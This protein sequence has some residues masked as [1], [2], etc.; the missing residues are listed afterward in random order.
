MKNNKILWTICC[1]LTLAS[2]SKKA[3]PIINPLDYVNPF[4][5]TGGHGHT[6]PGATVPFGMVQLSPDT[7]LEG[8][9]GCSGY[10]YS[11]S[12]IYGF[13]HTHLSGTG[14]SDYG[15]ILVMPFNSEEK[16]SLQ[17]AFNHQL[18][19]SLFDKKSEKASPGSYKV[20]IDAGKV[21]LTATKRVGIHEYKFNQR[22]NNKVFIDLNHRDKVLDCA[23]QLK[24][25][26]ITGKRISHAWAEEQHVYFAMEFS[27]PFEFEQIKNEQDTFPLFTVLNF[28][29]CEKLMVKVGISASSVE[30]AI[31]NL[32]TEAGHWDFEKYLK[33]AEETWKK[34]LSKI[35]VSGTNED[36][37]SIFYTALYHSMI[38]PNTISDVNGDYRGMD[39]K[40]YKERH[41]TQYTIFSLWDTFRGAHPLYTIIERKRTLAFIESMLNHYKQGGRLPV[42]E[43]SANETDCMIGYHSVSVIVDAYN[44]GI[45]GFDTALALEAMTHSANLDHLG[46]KAYKEKGFIAAGDEAESVSKTLEYAYD[47]WCIALFAKSMGK[48]SLFNEFIKRAQYYKNLYN[49]NNGF[50]QARMNGGWTQNFQPSEVNFNYTEANSWQ[51]SL[52]VPQDI[53][54]LIQLHGGHES[55]E[56]KLDELF[57]T[58]MELSGRHQVDITGLIGQYAHGNEPSHHMAY[59]Y[60]YI[61]KAYKTQEK[62]H[63]ILKEQYHNAPDGL[64]GNEDCGQMSAWYVLSSM[65]FYSVTPGLPYY[66]IGTPNFTKA[67]I[68]LE[69][70]KN[71]VIQANNLSAD[72]FYIQSA[73]LNGKPYT[74]SFIS[75]ENIMKGGTLAF[76]MGNKPN[77][78]WGKEKENQPIATIQKQ[79][80]TTA[81]P[82]IAARSQTFIDSLKI[83]IQSIDK[84]SAV[85]YQ[86]NEGAFKKYMGPFYIKKMCNIKAFSV[87]KNIQSQL[88]EADFYKIKGGRSIRILTPYSN[89]YAAAGDQTL[90]DYLRGSENYRT[91]YWQG[92]QGTNVEVIIDLGIPTTINKI[93][94]GTLQDIKSWIW[95]PKSVDLYTSVK[96]NKFD[97]LAHLNNEHS[98][99]QYGA[100]LQDFEATNKSKAKVKFVKVILNYPG[101]CPQ[102]HLGAGGKAWI[103]VDEV[104]IE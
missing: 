9:D 48:D 50:M 65:G 3:A 7:R 43:L 95:F 54:G 82:V 15:D 24:D 17:Q 39:Q 45:R 90:I 13:S 53:E 61:G 27:Q 47:D 21:R 96:G 62:V 34:A 78:N 58:Q 52:F 72:N 97:K 87:E 6:Y 63:Q 66:T 99:A 73:T 32:K 26:M 41:H 93:K 35:E 103:F 77:K 59:L 36:E 49:P 8:W 89:Q 31:L 25:N 5:G 98:N 18:T 29:N 2:C 60:N 75:H 83:E 94:V 57:S 81:V 79:F 76:E 71:F 46:L 70:G 28:T 11:D 23:I 22:E 64:S 104:F 4:I 84:Q 44:K 37:I 51:Y 40:I 101:D 20:A 100:Y 38:V 42:W 12:L 14:V 1:V 88:I 80:K 19:P 91:G 16:L 56:A 102:W 69:N 30:N 67:N 92:Y 10:H 68:H 74:H 33:S 55:F 86:L 85:Y